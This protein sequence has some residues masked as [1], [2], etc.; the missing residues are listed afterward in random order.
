VYKCRRVSGLPKG[1]RRYRSL[2]WI[3]KN[4]SELNFGEGWQCAAVYRRPNLLFKMLVWV[5][6]DDNVA[7]SGFLVARHGSAAKVWNV[8][9]FLLG[10]LQD[11]C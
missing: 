2:G 11:L 4:G 8:L 7:T 10:R 1:P 9:L 3:R 6:R 5:L